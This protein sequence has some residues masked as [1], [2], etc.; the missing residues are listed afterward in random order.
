[1][2]VCVYLS[3]FCKAKRESYAFLW[4]MAVVEYAALTDDECTLTV[5][6]SSM[7]TKGYGLALQHGSP[8]RDLFSQ[9]WVL[10]HCLS[11]SL[12][13]CVSFCLDL[14]TFALNLFPF[15]FHILSCLSLP[16]VAPQS[17]LQWRR[18]LYTLI[19]ELVVYTNYQIIRNAY[20]SLKKHLLYLISSIFCIF[21]TLNGFRS[22]YKI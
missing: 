19:M 3:L 7:S 8:Y 10:P 1:M 18:L 14:N 13:T 2:C 20:N 15:L 11:L 22:T 16:T 4:D 9:K 12:S 6:G 5:T 21:V 17:H